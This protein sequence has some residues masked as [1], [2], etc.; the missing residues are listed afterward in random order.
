M[1]SHYS[2]SKRNN[3]WV[4]TVDGSMLMICE[5]KKAAIRAVMEATARSESKAVRAVAR[6]GPSPQSERH[7]AVQGMGVA[8]N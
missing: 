3:G 6:R 4:I 1:S 7:A 2:I 8:A 5:R